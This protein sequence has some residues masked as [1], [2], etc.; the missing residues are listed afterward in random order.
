MLKLLIGKDWI[1]NRNEIFSR[2]AQDVHNK[3]GNRILL[4]PELISH[5]CERILC[6]TSGDTSS[7]GAVLHKIGPQSIRLFRSSGGSMPG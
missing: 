1:S 6:A 3:Q 2:I 7:R 4:V 5:E